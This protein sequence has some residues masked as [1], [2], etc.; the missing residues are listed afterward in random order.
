MVRAT[1]DGDVQARL[2]ALAARIDA[3]LDRMR[4][5]FAPPPA[6]A[7]A[8]VPVSGPELD[9]LAAA[10]RDAEARALLQAQRC[11]AL[12]DQVAKLEAAKSN[13]V[14]LDS[15]LAE[16]LPA[17]LLEVERLSSEIAELRKS[18]EDWR[19][20]ARNQRRELDN[21]VPKLEQATAQLSE[22]RAR[23]EWNQKR[24]G[25]LERTIAEQRRELEVA[26]RR[27]QH[28]RQHITVR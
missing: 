6:A 24:I 26:E 20:Q 18:N 9:A 11:Q 10:L 25:E 7:P 3:S 17:K 19:T 28:M 8:P 23:D 22:L 12:E 1:R 2:E 15:K 14:G 27:A 16:M 13:Q 5:V 4:E 21:V